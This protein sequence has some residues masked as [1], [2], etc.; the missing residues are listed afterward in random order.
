VI[1]HACFGEEREGRRRKGK[2]EK[3]KRK[4]EF[5]CVFMANVLLLLP[6]SSVLFFFFSFSLSFHTIYYLF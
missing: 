3:G 5:G 4:S 6:C 2:K 1:P